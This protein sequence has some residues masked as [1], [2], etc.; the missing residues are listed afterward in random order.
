MA[1]GFAG[2]FKLRNDEYTELTQRLL[3]AGYTMHSRVKIENPRYQI[4]KDGT[5]VHM[6][7]AMCQLIARNIDSGDGEIAA[8]TGAFCEM[9]SE[10]VGLLLSLATPNAITYSRINMPMFIGFCKHGAYLAS[11]PMAFPKDLET[12]PQPLPACS[13]GQVEKDRF[14]IVPYQNPPTR[15]EMITSK[16]KSEAYLRTCELLREGEHIFPDV[17][18]KA[19][20]PLFAS[21]QCLPSAQLAYETLYYLKK[22]GRLNVQTVRVPGVGGNDAPKFML[23]LLK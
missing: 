19:V 8:M 3:D 16:I 14:T 13:S 23:S 15:V 5:A 1:N 10:I 18:K 6:S 9:P 12:E 2:A 11:T 17:R 20:A 7:D 4:L 21:G 22:E